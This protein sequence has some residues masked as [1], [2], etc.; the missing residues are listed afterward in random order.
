M[1]TRVIEVLIDLIVASLVI[2]INESSLNFLLVYI[3]HH[4]GFIIV[5][6]ERLLHACVCLLSR[7]PSLLLFIQRTIRPPIETSPFLISP[8]LPLLLSHLPSNSLRLLLVLTISSEDI[9]HPVVD[10][11]P[12]NLIDNLSPL[13]SINLPLKVGSLNVLFDDERL[14]EL[15]LVS[16]TLRA[17]NGCLVLAIKQEHLPVLEVVVGAH[18]AGSVS[19]VDLIVAVE[20]DDQ[21]FVGLIVEDQ[22]L[23]VI[24][25]HLPGALG[26]EAKFFP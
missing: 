12:L 6:L 17:H 2:F 3:I 23:N 13:D 5:S 7:S 10:L 24:R 22:L 15:H 8:L 9:H 4:H 26:R 18:E 1:L 14:L 25:D 20:D 16:S 11:K 21:L 19:E